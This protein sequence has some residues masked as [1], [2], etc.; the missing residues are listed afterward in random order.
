MI[1]TI[2][3]LVSL[4][5]I[6]FRTRSDLALENLVLRPATRP[7]EST[8][9]TTETS[10]VRSA[11]LGSPLPVLGTLERDTYYHRARTHFALDKDAP[12]PRSVQPPHRGSGDRDP[13]SR[14][15]SPSLR[16]ARGVVPVARA[17]LSQFPS[18]RV[19]APT[20]RRFSKGRRSPHTFPTATQEGGNRRAVKKAQHMTGTSLLK[21]SC[22]S[23]SL[24]SSY[25]H[26]AWN[27]QSMSP[28]SG[29]EPDSVH[30]REL[31]SSTLQS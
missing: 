19:A 29:T 27:H 13:G 22:T 15:S 11:L 28:R 21:T 25:V 26:I 10:E 16:E 7:P 4:I 12:E 2:L 3:Q 31:G 5:P 8:S 23:T 9:P 18:R 14:Q 6:A 30:G 1:L 20:P 24:P 17:A